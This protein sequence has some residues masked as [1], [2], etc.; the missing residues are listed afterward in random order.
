M[1]GI[2][3]YIGA[4]NAVEIL[5]D[6]LRRLEYRGYD[7]AGLAIQTPRGLEVRRRAG[8]I[9][10]LDRLVATEPLEGTVGL[11]HTRWATHGRPADHNAHPHR[12]CSGDLAVVHNGIL[13]NYLELKA[14]LEAQGHRFTSETDTEIVA[15]LV[16]SFVSGGAELAAAVNAAL[17]KIRG[18]FAICVLSGRDPGRIVVAKRGAGA[19]VIGLGDREIFVA[20]DIPAVLPHTR[21]VV[22]LEDDEIAVLHRDGL[23]SARRRRSPG[24]P[25]WQKKAAIRTSCSRR[26]TSSPRPWP[27]RCGGAWIS[28]PAWCICPRRISP[29][30]WSPG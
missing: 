3:G 24:M 12:D 19:V 14:A 10:H 7:S 16:E 4:R 8:R 17:Q 23:S 27:T 11:G 18:A 21:Q 20:S 5:L 29:R 26:S 1:C 9:D 2:F 28:K 30:R 22:L 15:H 6:G 13:E 25:R